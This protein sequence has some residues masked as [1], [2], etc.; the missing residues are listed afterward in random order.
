MMKAALIALLTATT[1]HNVAAAA[2]PLTRAEKR[3]CQTLEQCISIIE[4]HPHDSF[5]YDL[6][7]TEF[8]RYGSRGQA[9]LLRLLDRNPDARAN[10]ADLLARSNSPALIAQL[11]IMA[12]SSDPELG[13]MTRDTIRAVAAHLSDGV[14]LPPQTLLGLLATAEAQPTLP[15]LKQLLKFPT[16]DIQSA[17]PSQ[18]RSGDPDIAELAYRALH[19]YAPSQALGE[20][21]ESVNETTN[22]T[23]AMALGEMMARLDRRSPNGGYS[24][25]LSKASRDLSLSPAMQIGATYGLLLLTR[26]QAPSPAHP[27]LTDRLIAIDSVLRTQGRSLSLGRVDATTRRRF[28]TLTGAAQIASDI[29]VEACTLGQTLDPAARIGRL[30]FFETGVTLDH[31]RPSAEFSLPVYSRADRG[32]LRSALS[33]AGGWLAGYGDDQEG[34]LIWYANADN[35]PTL[36]SGGHTIAIFPKVAQQMGRLPLNAWAISTLPDG[37]TELLSIDIDKPGAH[38]VSRRH[39]VLPGQP[40]RYGRLPDNSLLISMTGQTPVRLSPDGTIHR[41]CSVGAIPTLTPTP[42]L[43]GGQTGTDTQ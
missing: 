35:T 36:L 16:R 31:R 25:V 4:R 17:L 10:A 7:A 6:L 19:A 30:P 14:R 27:N 24:A 20:L 13:A 21:R 18:L 1:V 43:A 11:S 39:A 5:D 29:G 28:A 8:A 32:L 42:S 41:G 3:V 12:S 40:V 33:L 2:N 34:S 37:A 26:K 38:P 9:E 22:I 23:H 15:V